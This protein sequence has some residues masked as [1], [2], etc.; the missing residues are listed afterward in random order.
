[1]LTAADP[2]YTTIDSPVA[3]NVWKIMVEENQIVKPNQTIAILEA[4]KLEISVNA[5]PD[6]K[7]AKV[8]RLL[9]A[10]GET[11]NAGARLALLKFEE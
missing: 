4:M 11:V 10:P 7:A 5:P 2:K 1:L 3:A 8:E 6:Q 9:V